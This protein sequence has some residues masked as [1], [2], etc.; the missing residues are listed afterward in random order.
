MNATNFKMIPRALLYF[1]SRMK[2]MASK[3]IKRNDEN[4]T[5]RCF[6]IVIY[7]SMYLTLTNKGEESFEEKF[8]YPP[9]FK[10]SFNNS[11]KSL[12]SDPWRIYHAMRP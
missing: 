10:D 9:A 2:L 7:K 11:L 4:L 6:T 8:V 5:R 1:L 3:L 12:C